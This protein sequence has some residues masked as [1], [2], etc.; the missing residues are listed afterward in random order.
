MINSNGLLFQFQS[1]WIPDDSYTELW[2][3]DGQKSA[4]VIKNSYLNVI[5]LYAFK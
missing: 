2:E 4:Q 5:Y 3:S 1:R